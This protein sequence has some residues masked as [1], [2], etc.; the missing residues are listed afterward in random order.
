MSGFKS[1]MAINKILG[2]EVLLFCAL[3]MV[4][5]INKKDKRQNVFIHI[6]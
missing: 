4:H 5:E 1:S 6:L 3:K 2:F